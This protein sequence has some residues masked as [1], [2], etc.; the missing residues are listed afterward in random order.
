MRAAA[1]SSAPQATE[2]QRQLGDVAR[3]GVVDSVDRAAARCVVRL[4][5]LLSPP[6]PWAALRAGA[7]KVWS[8]LSVGEQVMVVCPGGQISAG[9]VIAGVFQDAFAAPD[10]QDR[11]LIEFDDGARVIY[12]PNSSELRLEV[13]GGRVV[14]DGDLMVTGAV[15]VTGDVAAGPVGQ[16]I[17]LRDH[18]HAGVQT[19][20]GLTLKPQPE[21]GT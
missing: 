18:R 3:W 5:D 1:S 14:V 7:V 10:D 13:A 6:L 20:P 17:S 21:L 8:P 9:L 11:F 2:L 4:G 19:G 12:D 16:V 15:R